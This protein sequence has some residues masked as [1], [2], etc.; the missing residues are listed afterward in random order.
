MN[1]VI[2][3]NLNGNAYQ[4]EERGYQLLC[5]YLDGAETQLKDNPD[6]A[7]IISDLEQ[8]IA[9]KCRNF[10]GPQKTI[11][12][13]SEIEQIIQAMGPVDSEGGEAGGSPEQDTST[14]D[15][16]NWIV[17][18]GNYGFGHSA[19]HRD[20]LLGI[21][22]LAV[23]PEAL[24]RNRLAEAGLSP[25]HSILIPSASHRLLGRGENFLRRVEIRKSLRQ[26]DR[27]LIEGITRDG[28]DHGFLKIVEPVGGVSF[29][30]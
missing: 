16:I 4:V 6:R 17:Q 19:G 9:D 1:K 20:M 30:G 29:H 28:A 21:D 7:E 14:P 8:A 18:G 26:Q 5:E 23:K 15:E 22:F 11:V 25:G 3:I 27:S 10:L 13:T 24:L 12:T 2:T